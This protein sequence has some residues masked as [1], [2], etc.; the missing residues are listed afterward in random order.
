MFG[1]LASTKLV[2]GR[3]KEVISGLQKDGRRKTD[4]RVA[5]V[6]QARTVEKTVALRSVKAGFAPAPT[7]SPPPSG[8]EVGSPM[9]Q[10]SPAADARHEPGQPPLPSLGDAVRADG[11]VSLEPPTAPTTVTAHGLTWAA[12]GVA[13]S[14]GDPVARRTWSVRTLPGELIFEE[15]D[16][17]GQ[18]RAPD[19]YFLAM[20][21]MDQLT[22]MVRLT[23]PAL[24]G[25]GMQ[26]TT[27]G[28][29]LRFIGVT[30]LAT[31]Y[32]F[33][34]RAELWSNKPRNPYLIAPAFDERT[35]LSRCRFD[36]LWSCVV[37]SEQ[38]SGGRDDSEQSRWEFI[39]DFIESINAHRDAHMSPSE[40]ICVDESMCKWYGEGGPW[41]KRGLPMYVAIDRKP[42]NG[43]EIQNAACGRS[44]IM[45]RLSVVTSAEHQRAVGTNADGGVPHGAAVLK[46]LVAP[47]AG[48]QRLVCADSNCASVTAAT[49]LLAMGLRFIGVVK[50]ATPGYPM[51]ALSALEVDTRG[52]HATFTHSTPEGTM[53][54]MALMWVDR[55]RRYFVSST[56]TSLPGNPYDRVRW[57]QMG[58][59]AERVALKFKLPQ[60]AQAY[61]ECC[62]QIDRHNRCR[63]NDLQLEHKLPTHDWS[64][65]VSVSLLGMCVVDSWLLYSGARGETAA[66]TQRQ[67]YEDLAAHLISLSTLLGSGRVRRRH[68]RRWRRLGL[69]CATVLGFMYLP[70]GSV[71]AAHLSGPATTGISVT[72]VC[73]RDTSRPRSA[74]AVEVVSTGR[75]SCA[76][77]RRG[78][79]V[80]KR[81]CALC[82]SWTCSVDVE[83]IRFRPFSLPAHVSLSESNTHL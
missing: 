33:G 50:T 72:A 83:I 24:E 6:I 40:Y 78:D 31:R 70:G 5:W 26:P 30:I 25:R 39:T 57:L 62:A 77:P 23:S 61:Y 7:P 60:V 43:C 20:F 29:L 67:F 68:L 51:S 56:S 58:E 36:S 1:T 82:M 8:L 12:G 74:R 53:K 49:E 11:A 2:S 69:L 4:L 81:I 63:Q 19:E 47:W 65:R 3:V 21:P 55:E 54:L 34:S 44:G 41:I 46:R 16:M 18:T 22:R 64:M 66:L 35:G 42:E 73:A 28:E 17:V 37:F 75:C 45:L 38:K 13:E 10:A 14:V 59:D 52:D 71:A 79:L 48:T 32:E 76:A 9:T 27:R 15:G 80:L